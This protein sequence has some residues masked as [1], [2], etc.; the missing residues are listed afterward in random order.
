MQALLT[1]LTLLSVPT[2]WASPHAHPHRRQTSN[3]TVGQTVDTTSGSVTGH[4]ASAYSEVSEYL[5]IPFGQ[6]PVGN[7]RFAAPVRYEGSG[8][9]N[10]STFGNTCA[11]LSSSSSSAPTA[12]QIAFSNITAVGLEFLS[13]TTAANVVY[14]E[15]CLYLNIWTKPQSGEAKKAVMVYLYGGGFSSGSSSVSVYNGAALAEKEDVIIVNFNYR[16][17]ILGFPGNPSAQGNLGFLDQRL[18]LEWIRDNIASFGGDPS[19]ITLF[20]QSAGGASTDYY[21]YAFASDPI[22]YALIEQS[23]TAFSF[24]LP[25]PASTIATNWYTVTS[26]VG[27]GNASTDSTAQLSCMRNVSTDAIFAAVPNS[28]VNA[29][30]SPFG[31]TVDGEL[32][33]ANYSALPAPDIPLL[34][35]SNDYEA[36][37]FRTELAL[38]GLA[39]A[40]S[41]WEEMNLSSYTCPIGQRA[42]ASFIAS[43]STSTS[44]DECTS[45]SPVWRYRFHGVFPNVNISSE[46][47]AFH[48]IELQLLFGTTFSSPADTP[49][50][51]AVEKYIQGA[52]TTFAKDPVNGLKSYEGG[53]PT[54]DPAEKTLIRLAYGNELGDGTNLEYP[55][56]YDAACVG[57]SLA[58]L[59]CRIFGECSL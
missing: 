10:A 12:E 27:C 22:V 35:G 55:E 50:E 51:I 40:D 2:V 20:G 26:A 8:A 17:S 43:T 56:V 25:Y 42:N 18:A 32:V 21:S 29:L 52:W 57:A 41:D 9:I 3:F 30:L 11:T 7:L 28:G 36:G 14:S 47:G 33:F 15:D 38:G 1:V 37:L 48:G 46:A 34:V 44:E 53:W 4:A 19:R 45:S 31:P 13:E 54:Y 59:L 6:P 39:F 24:G 58:D 5:G 49:A 16:V 23:G